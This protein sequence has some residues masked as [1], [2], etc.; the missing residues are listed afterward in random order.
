MTAVTTATTME[1]SDS[2]MRVTTMRVADPAEPPSGWADPP[3]S[4][5]IAGGARE[6][7]RQIRRCHPQERTP[8]RTTMTMT[9]V[10][11]ATTMAVVATGNGLGFRSF[12]DFNFLSFF[13][14]NYFCLWLEK[15]V[16]LAVCKNC[17]FVDTW[18]QAGHPPASKSILATWKN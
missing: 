2:G 4:R 7:E 14:R 1:G 12:W 6:G 9:V 13:H 5:A 18:V 16:V 17:D 11:T 15:V 8:L 10:V 3:P